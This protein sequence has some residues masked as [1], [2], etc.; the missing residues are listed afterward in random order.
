MVAN[1]LSLPVFVFAWMRSNPYL[2]EHKVAIILATVIFVL[3]LL[4]RLHFYLQQESV[5]T[6]E[7]CLM[8]LL[9]Q[10]GQQANKGLSKEG[11]AE[12]NLISNE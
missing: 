10:P 1:L 6:Y 5:Y 3:A 8:L 11:S 7:A 9:K 4:K 12:T 2:Q